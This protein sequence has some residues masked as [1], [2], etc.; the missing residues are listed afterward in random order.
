M[1]SSFYSNDLL[2]IIDQLELLRI[3]SLKSF[4]FIVVA[5]V[6]INLFFYFKVRGNFIFTFGLGLAVL[7]GAYYQY[8][9]KYRKEV[10]AMLMPKLAYQIDPS[11]MYN[12]NQQVD[13]YLINRLRFFSHTIRNQMD[14]GSLTYRAKNGNSAVVFP[15]KLESVKTDINEGK[16]YT[17][18]FEG[19]FITLDLNRQ[20]GQTY[21]IGPKLNRTPLLEAG[22]SLTPPHMGLREVMQIDRDWMLYSPDGTVRLSE[23]LLTALKSFKQSVND[24]AYVIFEGNHLYILLESRYKGVEISIFRSLKSST[25]LDDKAALIEEIK[26]LCEI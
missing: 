9:E 22:D 14:E 13:I 26:A 4:G 10:Q 5:V 2:R 6:L 16:H 17:P 7:L 1:Q 11:L 18:R 20:Y 12:P 3:D 19:S 8:N 21:L 23:K 15:V 24:N 25:F